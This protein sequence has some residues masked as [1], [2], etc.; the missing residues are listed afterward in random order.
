MTQQQHLTRGRVLRSS[1]FV[2][3]SPYLPAL[4]LLVLQ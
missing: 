4:L 2:Y 3:Q 1:V